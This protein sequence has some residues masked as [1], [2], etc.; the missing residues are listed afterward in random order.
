MKSYVSRATSA[1]CFSPD[2]DTFSSVSKF[3]LIVPN[4][5]LRSWSDGLAAS[6]M[7]AS[8]FAVNRAP[9]SIFSNAAT[10]FPPSSKN[11][12]GTAVPSFCS[13]PVNSDADFVASMPTTLSHVFIASAC[14]RTSPSDVPKYTAVSCTDPPSFNMLSID[15]S[16]ARL[17][18]TGR[19]SFCALRNS[20]LARFDVFC[21]SS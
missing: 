6:P 20:S 16:Q 21:A 4:V 3:R 18:S 19:R 8:S 7:P 1:V 15:P 17:V 11:F 10:A 13:S 5:A 14:L 9:F 12:C 2:V